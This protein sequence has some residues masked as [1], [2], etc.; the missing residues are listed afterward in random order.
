LFTTT[1]GQPRNRIAAFDLASG[2]LLDWNPN[3]GGAFGPPPQFPLPSV[4]RIA[5]LG[6]T[7]VAGGTFN[8]VGGKVHSNLVGIT[9]PI[10]AVDET[11]AASIASWARV[12]PNPSSGRVRL[13]YALPQAGHVRVR[14][15]DVRG[16]Q[17]ASLADGPRP[18]GRHQLQW[19]APTGTG[20]GIYFVRFETP[21]GDLTRSVV[22]IP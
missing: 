14:V 8:H 17:I 1:G 5:T 2:S 22:V 7:V 3:A 6:G 13:E 21:R 18:S 4:Q 10:V 20:P 19:S 12:S 16:R 9:S 11:P 15:Y